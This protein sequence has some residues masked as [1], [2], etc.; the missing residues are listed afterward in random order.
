MARIGRSHKGGVVLFPIRWVDVTLDLE[1]NDLGRIAKQSNT[2]PPMPQH[3]PFPP[4]TRCQ[5]SHVPLFA[6]FN[7]D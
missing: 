6:R 3:K 1:G 7:V 4:S 5:E 2:R